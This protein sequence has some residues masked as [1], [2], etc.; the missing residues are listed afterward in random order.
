[1]KKLLLTIICPA[2]LSISNTGFG[3]A[4][5]LGTAANFVLFSTNGAVSNTGISQVTGNV[6]RKEGISYRKN[7][8]FSGGLVGCSPSTT[9]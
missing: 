6:G 4:P 8:V 7:E 1:M 3:Q 9:T 2:L 5:N